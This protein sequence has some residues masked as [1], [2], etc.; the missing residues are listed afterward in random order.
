[1]KNFYFGD[2]KQ[3]CIVY[4]EIWYWLLQEVK[5]LLW[6][7]SLGEQAPIWR[8]NTCEVQCNFYMP[9]WTMQQ[10]CL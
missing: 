8:L 4:S 10:I 6:L 3:I 9:C 1:M 5:L 7:E 2:R